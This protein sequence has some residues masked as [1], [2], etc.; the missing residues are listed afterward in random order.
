VMAARL[1]EEQERAC[2]EAVLSAGVAPE[3]YASTLL[4]TARECPN[5]LLL[6]CAMSTSVQFG[7]CQGKVE[8]SY[9]EQSRNVLF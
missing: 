6:G 9:S 1:D 3:D 7:A 8:M 2:D 4:N 5:P